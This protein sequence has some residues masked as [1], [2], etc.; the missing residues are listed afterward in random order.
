MP[1]GLSSGVA[2]TLIATAV[3]CGVEKKKAFKTL[4]ILSSNFFH[5]HRRCSNVEKITETLNHLEFVASSCQEVAN[6]YDKGTQQSSFTISRAK[7][8]VFVECVHTILLLV[9]HHFSD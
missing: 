5:L 6:V 4:F 2:I 9:T 3:A 1:R 8:Q 7:E